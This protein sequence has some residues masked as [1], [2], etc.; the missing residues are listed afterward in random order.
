MIT[1]HIPVLQTISLKGWQTG[2][3]EQIGLKQMCM[4]QGHGKGNVY[5]LAFKLLFH[6]LKFLW[7]HSSVLCTV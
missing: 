6:M 1:G 7:C 3:G 4:G 5:N 2:P